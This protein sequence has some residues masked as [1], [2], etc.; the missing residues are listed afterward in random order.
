MMEYFDGATKSYHTECRE[1]LMTVTDDISEYWV[2]IE[3]EKA[4]D[5][6][7]CTDEDVPEEGMIRFLYGD[8]DWEMIFI[9]DG[10]MEELLGVRQIRLVAFRKTIIYEDD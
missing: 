10:A 3:L 1:S 7:F 9:N 6:R 4:S 2:D 5:W 8:R